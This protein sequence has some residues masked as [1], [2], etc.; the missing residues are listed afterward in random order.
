[1]R[2]R[3]AD[4]EDG[5]IESRHDRNKVLARFCVRAREAPKKHMLMYRTC[6]LF[7]SRKEYKAWSLAFILDS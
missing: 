7:A 4:R 5:D 6:A 1:M 2:C 3:A